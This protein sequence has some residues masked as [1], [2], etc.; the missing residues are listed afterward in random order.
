MRNKKGVFLAESH[1]EE[2]PFSSFEFTCHYPEKNPEG[3]E[4]DITKTL[5]YVGVFDGIE[6]E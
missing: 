1:R 2:T 5:L 3:A 4:K 6:K